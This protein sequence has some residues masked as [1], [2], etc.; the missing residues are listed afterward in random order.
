[1]TYGLDKPTSYLL[2]ALSSLLGKNPEAKSTNEIIADVIVSLSKEIMGKYKPNLNNITGI[3]TIGF[4]NLKL[5]ADMSVP[6]DEFWLVN[7]D[8]SKQV[9]KIRPNVIMAKPEA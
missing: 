8:G 4:D 1:M 3:K 7:P 2:R 9:F 6:E 5:V